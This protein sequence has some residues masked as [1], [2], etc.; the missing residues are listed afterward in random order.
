MVL[1]FVYYETGMRKQ[2]INKLRIPLKNSSQ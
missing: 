2:Q 1:E